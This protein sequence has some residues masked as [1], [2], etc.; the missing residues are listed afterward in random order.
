MVSAKSILREFDS[1][2]PTRLLHEAR[3]R[4]GWGQ[5]RVYG[6]GSGE[7]LAADRTGEGEKTREEKA[8]GL[9]PQPENCVANAAAREPNGSPPSVDCA[10]TAFHNH[11]HYPK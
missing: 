8:I 6:H 2:P 9:G 10:L 7:L 5:A 4:H 11:N 1:G 3:H